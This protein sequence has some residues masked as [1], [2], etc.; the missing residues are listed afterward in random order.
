MEKE[1]LEDQRFA[2]AANVT[3]ADGS[4]EEFRLKQTC[5]PTEAAWTYI[6]T[7]TDVLV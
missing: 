7:I 1:G 5:T 4:N 6:T 3:L 2:S